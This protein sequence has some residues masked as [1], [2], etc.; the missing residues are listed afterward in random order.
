MDFETIL[1]PKCAPRKQPKTNK[2]RTLKK[3]TKKNEQGPRPH[4]PPTPAPLPARSARGR[5]HRVSISEGP[6]R[7][8]GTGF[9]SQGTGFPSQ[10]GENR[11]PRGRVGKGLPFRL[12]LRHCF[13][14]NRFR[15]RLRSISRSIDFE[16]EGINDDFDRFSDD[17][18]TTTPATRRQVGGFND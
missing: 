8:G 17:F 10:T 13:R 2:K 9:P 15:C 6:V 4:L 14:F 1:V 18:T 11:Y 3:N 12:R 5:G 7:R 16:V